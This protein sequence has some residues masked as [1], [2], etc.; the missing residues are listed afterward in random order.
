MVSHE[1]VHKHFLH[2][3]SGGRGKYLN[4]LNKQTFLSIYFKHIISGL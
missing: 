3:S 2:L 1:S 4:T